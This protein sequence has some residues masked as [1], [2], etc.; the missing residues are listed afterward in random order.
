MSFLALYY[1]GLQFALCHT[2]LSFSDVWAINAI[3]KGRNGFEIAFT[4]LQFVAT[5]IAGLFIPGAIKGPYLATY[6]ADVSLV[7]SYD[8][9]K[10]FFSSPLNPT[11]EPRETYSSDPHARSLGAVIFLTSGAIYLRSRHRWPA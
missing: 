7:V 1:L 8:S 6:L 11:Q 2:W 4:T 3:A 10:L 5:G 9:Q